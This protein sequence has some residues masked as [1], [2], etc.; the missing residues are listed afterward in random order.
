MEDGNG[1]DTTTETESGAADTLMQTP[2]T[3]ESANSTSLQ[4]MEDLLTDTPSS[5]FDPADEV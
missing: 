4:N 2:N 3:F 5:S 1:F